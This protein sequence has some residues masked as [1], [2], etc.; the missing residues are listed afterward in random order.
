MNSANLLTRSLSPEDC[1]V[2]CLSLPAKSIKFILLEMECSCFSPF[3]SSNYNPNLTKLYVERKWW[4][5]SDIKNIYRMIMVMMK[6]HKWQIFKASW[7]LG[8]SYFP[9][10]FGNGNCKANRW[11]LQQQ[12]KQWLQG[13]IICKIER[14]K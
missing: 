10:M 3:K 11:Y 4:W 6:K 8:E 2:D 7:W 9:N 13:K 1:D 5:E 12:V 14:K